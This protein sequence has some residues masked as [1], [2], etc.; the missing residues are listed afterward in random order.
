MPKMVY[1]IGV[2]VST[3]T[4]RVLKTTKFKP[5]EVKAERKEPKWEKRS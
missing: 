3:L 5:R 1:I 2:N 4:P